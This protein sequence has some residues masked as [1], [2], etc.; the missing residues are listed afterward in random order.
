MQGNVGDTGD[1]GVT[2]VQVCYM[3]YFTPH[4]V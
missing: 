4:S 3:I 2:G 1:P